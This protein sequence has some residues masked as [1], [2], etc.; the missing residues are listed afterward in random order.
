[1]RF[2]RCKTHMEC[3]PFPAMYSGPFFHEL[4]R[5][6]IV[7]F[8]IKEEKKI[9]NKGRKGL[10]KCTLIYT[11]HVL[12]TTCITKSFLHLAMEVYFQPMKTFDLFIRK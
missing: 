5:E 3:S 8:L 7:L 12:K 1:M 10:N 2:K 6:Y 9:I 11:V 4:I